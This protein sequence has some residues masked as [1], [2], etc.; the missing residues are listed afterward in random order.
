[1]PLRPQNA[2]LG[3]DMS[4][5]TGA[6]WFEWSLRVNTTVKGNNIWGFATCYQLGY[7]KYAD[8]YGVPA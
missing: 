6:G 1:M 2:N 4:A 5:A 7:L 8:L 3:A